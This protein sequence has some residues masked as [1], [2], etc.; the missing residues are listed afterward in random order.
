[1]AQGSRPFLLRS[2]DY[3]VFTRVRAHLDM[4]RRLFLAVLAVRTF[5]D[6]VANATAEAL[7]SNM[8]A[9]KISNATVSNSN[10]LHKANVAVKG[11]PLLRG[12]AMWIQPCA[13]Y[14]S[15]AEYCGYNAWGQCGCDGYPPEDQWDGNGRWSS[16]SDCKQAC[17]N[18]PTCNAFTMDA[19][20]TK[21]W[22][23]SG[24]N[25]QRFCGGEPFNTYYY[26]R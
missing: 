12:T 24:C 16:W 6:D 19:S 13:H 18:S 9:A 21:C 3:A 25:P 20:E 2:W 1:M 5:G 4:A 10:S 17:D 8:T 22:L 14:G 15:F 26:T 11:T 7:A 23:R